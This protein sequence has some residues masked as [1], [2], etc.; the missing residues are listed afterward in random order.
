MRF[1][2]VAAA[3]AATEAPVIGILTVP[4]L[5]GDCITVTNQLHSSGVRREAVGSCF[6][7][8]YPE[9]IGA[10][11]GRVVPI[12]YD[13]PAAELERLKATRTE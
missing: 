1:S 3:A 11:G 10:A 5:S 8:L 6:D 4:D 2:A 12:R 7:S 13:A 9:W